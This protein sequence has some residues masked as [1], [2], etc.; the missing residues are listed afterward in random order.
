MPKTKT[1]P[2]RAYLTHD[3]GLPFSRA[4]WF[5]WAKDGLIPPLIKIGGRTLVP[6]STIEAII[7]GRIKLPSNAGARGKPPTPRDRGGHAKR[8]AKSRKP[9]L[10]TASA[11]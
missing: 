7:D 10:A 5:R 2:P 4:S 8:R 6:S 11:E 1:V 3:T 9:A